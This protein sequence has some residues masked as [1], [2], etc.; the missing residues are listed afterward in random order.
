MIKVKVDETVNICDCCGK[1]NL[2]RTLL[3][4]HP[5]NSSINLGV[6]CAGQW[7]DQNLSGNPY[8]AAERLEVYI[9]HISEDAY[10]NIIDEI[11]EDSIAWD[12][13]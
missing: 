13:L 3:L 7:F 9:N 4:I 11:K 6:T 10:L 8:T 2:K 12:S 1:S 5:D